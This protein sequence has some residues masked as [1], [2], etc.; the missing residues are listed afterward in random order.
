MASTSLVKK[1]DIVVLKKEYRDD[2]RI[3]FIAV[4]DEE[5]GRVIVEAEI[6]FRINPTYVVTRDMIESHDWVA[7]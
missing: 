6:G 1:G 5:K 3:I 7:E 2:D 4:D